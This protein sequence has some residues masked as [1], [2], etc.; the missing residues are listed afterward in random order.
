MTRQ[1]YKS[2]RHHNERVDNIPL[3]FNPIYNENGFDLIQPDRNSWTKP[4]ADPC[5]PPGGGANLQGAPTY[6]FTKFSQKLYEIERISIRPPRV[7]PLL[8]L[9]L[10]AA[11]R[12][13]I[14]VM[15]T[16][17]SCTDKK[18]DAQNTL[19]CEAT[20]THWTLRTITCAL[21]ANNALTV[22]RLPSSKLSRYRNFFLVLW[23]L[24]LHWYVFTF[25]NRPFSSV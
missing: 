23:P 25:H 21:I 13:C 10:Q 12:L 7:R 24:K 11:R 17:E 1:I 16:K 8:D 3:L 9:P 14:P 4:V 15:K 20:P 18:G 5:F 2:V 19:M 22:V 6:E